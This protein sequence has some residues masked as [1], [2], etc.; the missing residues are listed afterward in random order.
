M[1]KYEDS[2]KHMKQLKEI[3]L[4]REQAEKCVRC[5]LC[6]Y[7]CPVYAEEQD[8]NY[9]ARGR[10]RLVN[11][12]IDNHKDLRVGVKDRFSK[13]LLCRR[14]TMVCPQ[15]VR[16]DLLTVAA[17]AE[18]AKRDGLPVYKS[19]AFRKLLKDRSRMKKALKAASKLQRL[20]P[21]TKELEG[22][23]SFRY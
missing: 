2:T 9:V 19:V 17:R 16:T 14:C 6:L 1:R 7:V 20:F 4:V 13:C 18:L 10:N 12:I 21:V 23:F 11:E 8:E 15:G 5:G 22:F 3:D